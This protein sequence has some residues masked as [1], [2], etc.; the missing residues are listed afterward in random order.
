MTHH[1]TKLDQL[2]LTNSH[3]CPA[4]DCT[5]EMPF[6]QL[7]CRKH[8]FELPPKLRASISSMWR[9]GDLRGYLEARQDAVTF[10]EG[11]AG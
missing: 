1:P 3:P 9:R 4:R 11:L 7:A 8:W 2:D 6:E 10:W 5:E